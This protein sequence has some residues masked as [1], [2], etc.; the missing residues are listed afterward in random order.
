MD[1]HGRATG[2]V[3]TF[4][5][6]SLLMPA[7][8]G[9]Q[10]Q[11]QFEGIVGSSPEMIELFHIMPRVARSKSTVLLLGPSGTGK[12]LLARA[13]HNLSPRRKERFEAINCA[14]FP[15]SLLESELFGYKAG[16]FTGA[17]K[18]KPGRLLQANGGT[19]FLD[20]IG[21]MSPAM[22]VRLLRV[23][24]ER[25]IEPLGAL[26]PVPID[27]RVIAAT[28]R[29]L[30]EL[31]RQGQFRE[32]LFFR[33]KVIQLKL[34]SLAKRREDI[35]MLVRHLITRFNEKLER[36]IVGFFGSGMDTNPDTQLS[37]QYSRIGKH[38]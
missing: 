28:N 7:C 5:D 36:Q 21:D 17:R 22:Q 6:M 2:I 14:A 38:H 8:H 25:V 34:P 37:G 9:L 19:I 35:P 23:L 26:A 18:D 15:E 32:D 11:L 13:I 31:V 10:T 16:A 4:R 29:D 30:A 27:I 33:I 3:D 12:D 20:E 1:V 24:Q